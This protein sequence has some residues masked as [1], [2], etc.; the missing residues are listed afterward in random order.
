MKKLLLGLCTALI[1][2]TSLDTHALSK[3]CQDCAI[4]CSLVWWGLGCLA[5]INC[6]PGSS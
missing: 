4:A 5:C 1:L 3:D 2:S 6:P